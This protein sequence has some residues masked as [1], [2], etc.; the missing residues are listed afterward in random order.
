MIAVADRKDGRLSNAALTDRP[1]LARAVFEQ[2]SSAT[3]ALGIAMCTVAWWFSEL[4]VGRDVT[5]VRSAIAAAAGVVVVGGVTAWAVARRVR[6]PVVHAQPPAGWVYETRAAASQR[7]TR[8]ALVTVMGPVLLLAI[9]RLSREG[10][11]LAGALAGG[12]AAAS[13][14]L[15]IESR[16]WSRRERRDERFLYLPLRPHALMPPL[17]TVDVYARV[18]PDREG[19]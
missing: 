11:E 18:P 12:F 13:V 10:G 7:Q 14:C 8:L 5:P 15:F 4:A 1:R 6:R 19:V 3:I 17:A 9:D 16:A 2:R